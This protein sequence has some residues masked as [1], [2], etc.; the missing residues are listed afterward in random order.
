MNCL[1]CSWYGIGYGLYAA[2]TRDSVLRYSL[3]HSLRV[4]ELAC[5]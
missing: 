2:D 5:L 3:L 4:Q 1:H